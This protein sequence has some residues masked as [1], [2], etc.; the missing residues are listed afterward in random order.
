MATQVGTVRILQLY[1][2]TLTMPW[3]WVAN[4]QV[5]GLAAAGKTLVHNIGIRARACLVLRNQQEMNI[6]FISC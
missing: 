1:T 4:T 5:L 6:V 3:P 2:P